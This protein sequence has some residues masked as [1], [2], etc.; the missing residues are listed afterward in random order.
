MATDEPYVKRTQVEERLASPYYPH[1]L[2]GGN[3]AVGHKATPEDP[4]KR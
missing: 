4:I 3:P 1:R 2:S